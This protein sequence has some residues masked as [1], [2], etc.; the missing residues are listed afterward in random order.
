MNFFLI[1]MVKQIIKCK[2]KNLLE[3]MY[4]YMKKEWNAPQLEVLNVSQTMAGPGN[5]IPDGVQPDPDEAVHY[6]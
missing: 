3:R 6:S 1:F 4:E 5:N 2:K